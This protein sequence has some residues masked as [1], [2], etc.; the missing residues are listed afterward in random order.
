MVPLFP[1]QAKA[2]VLCVQPEFVHPV[3]SGAAQAVLET[4]NEACPKL[5]MGNKNKATHQNISMFAFLKS[6]VF[7]INN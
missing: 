4:G 1:V 5:S 7:F 3:G 6:S 2:E